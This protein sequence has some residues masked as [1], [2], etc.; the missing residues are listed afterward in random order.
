MGSA[1]AGS[2]VVAQVAAAT[3]SPGAGCVNLG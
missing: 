2:G 3:G 1:S